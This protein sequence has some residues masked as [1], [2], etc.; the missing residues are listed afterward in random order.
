MESTLREG[1]AIPF[2][3]DEPNTMETERSKRQQ[4]EEDK[5]SLER[6]IMRMKRQMTAQKIIKDKK[7]K[8]KWANRDR[9]RIQ[10]E[11]SIDRLSVKNAFKMIR[12]WSTEGPKHRWLTSNILARCQIETALR[13]KPKLRE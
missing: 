8:I 1:I 2:Q 4:I 9:T 3:D 7:T 10:W 13:K 12:P 6:Q 5:S 11:L